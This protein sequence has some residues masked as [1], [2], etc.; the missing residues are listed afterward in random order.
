MAAGFDGGAAQAAVMYSLIAAPRM[1]DVD[2]Q[3]WLTEVP[4]RIAEH[5]ARGL[6]E[7]PALELAITEQVI[8]G[9]LKCPA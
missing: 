3:A 5:L 6:D 7:L 2:P 9:G 1:N 8:A 4:V